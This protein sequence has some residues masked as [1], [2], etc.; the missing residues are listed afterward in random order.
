MTAR[1]SIPFDELTPEQQDA[2]AAVDPQFKRTARHRDM[3]PANA[4][5]P[6][7]CKGS[8]R[9]SAGL[10][11]EW[12]CV[13]EAKDAP[14]GQRA[15]DRR[16]RSPY[17]GT[18]AKR[19][20]SRNEQRFEAYLAEQRTAG[21]LSAWSYEVL[22]VKLPAR[23]A[24]AVLDFVVRATGWAGYSGLVVVEVKPR[25]KAT[26][27]PYFGPKGRLRIKLVAESL[28]GL[29]VPVLVAWPCG[30]G[31]SLEQIASAS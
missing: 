18:G 11:P 19:G 1:W 16:A 30:G 3:K 26:G 10:N 8:C 17:T 22:R 31:W 28:A 12:Y 25:D 2:A 29:E 4:K 7:T 20:M 14:E 13:M 27:T 23:K 21:R 15:L 9:G 6:C 24:T 5:H